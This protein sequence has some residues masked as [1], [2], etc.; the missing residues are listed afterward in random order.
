VRDTEAARLKEKYAAK[1]QTL[2]DRKRRAEDRVERETAQ[3]GHYRLNT[4]ISIGAT[5]LGALFGRSLRTTG[6][7]GRATT[8]ARSASRI[9]KKQAD[10]AR[11]EENAEVVQQRIE[12][13]QKEFEAD[14]AA[15]QAPIA[16][17]ALEIQKRTIRPRKSDIAVNT[18]GLCW[19]P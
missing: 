12:E 7:V 1:L 6:N 14:L 9:G 15:L 11:A 16:P 5:V 17:G 3:V 19:V 13:F 18:L 8:A 10:V 4:A 2:E